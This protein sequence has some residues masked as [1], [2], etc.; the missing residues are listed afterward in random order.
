[1]NN[2]DNIFNLDIQRH[3]KYSI[4]CIELAIPPGADFGKEIK[5]DIPLYA[6][7]LY[8][9]YIK[10]DLEDTDINIWNDEIG[11]II[12]ENIDILFNNYVYDSH[13]GIYN[14]SYVNMS[15]KNKL[16]ELYRKSK[17]MYI[18]L[19]FWFTKNTEN[20]LPLIALNNTN[21]HLVIKFN[22]KQALVKQEYQGDLHI[23]FPSIGILFDY[24]YLMDFERRFYLVNELEYIT[25]SKRELISF[26]MFNPEDVDN[27]TKVFNIDI[28]EVLVTNIE[29][30]FLCNNENYSYN[31]LFNYICRYNFTISK[32]PWVIGP[33]NLHFLKFV[34]SHSY[35]TSISNDLSFNLS[36]SL[37][38]DGLHPSGFLKFDNIWRVELNDVNT[39]VGDNDQNS[40]NKNYIEYN[41]EIEK[42]L[43]CKI[44]LD[45][46]DKMYINEG[47][48][49]EVNLYKKRYL[50]V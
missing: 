14:Y 22:N 13:K 26:N 29:I 20:A 36:F 5:I 19:N 10:I 27:N 34:H 38:G 39:R 12:Y 49:T 40:V 6:D 7:L 4:Q 33:Y 16:S 46:L 1:M 45:I 35:K 42:T 18:P 28:K 8:K 2:F 3:S 23:K 9:G 17:I 32:T 11:Y 25:K 43:E 31:E 15:K 24:V 21:I 30:K 41:K 47:V 37:L 44:T 50:N 48:L